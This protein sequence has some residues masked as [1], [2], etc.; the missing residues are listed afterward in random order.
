MGSDLHGLSGGEND[1]LGFDHEEGLSGGF[2]VEDGSVDEPV[3]WLGLGGDD[4]SIEFA[5]ISA[6]DALEESMSFSAGVGLGFEVDGHPF[7][8]ELGPDS[9]EEDSGSEPEERDDE[10]QELDELSDGLV[11]AHNDASD[12]EEIVPE[13]WRKGE[14]SFPP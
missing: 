14:S 13:G 4:K 11:K 1:F 7:V 5:D 10:G 9:G 6:N 12:G 8:A 2:P 3:H